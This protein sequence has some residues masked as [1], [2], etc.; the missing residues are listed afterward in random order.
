MC[1]DAIYADTK[2]QWV[3][4][5]PYNDKTTVAK[6]ELIETDRITRQKDSITETHTA[7]KIL[8]KIFFKLMTLN[9]NATISKRQTVSN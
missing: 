4:V 5:V 9:S 2:G 7:R 6:Q 1:D 8:C 3:E